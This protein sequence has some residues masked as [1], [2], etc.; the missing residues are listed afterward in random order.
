MRFLHLSGEPHAD[1]DALARIFGVTS[2]TITTWSTE[3]SFPEAVRDPDDRRKRFYSIPAAIRW[4]R[5]RDRAAL[6]G[7]GPE[8]A[9]PPIA[10]S[11]A[12]QEALKARLLKMQHDSEAGLLVS[13]NGVKVEL[14]HMIVTVK[15]RLL[16]VPTKAKARIPHLTRDDVSEIEELIRE[17]LEELTRAAGREVGRDGTVPDSEPA[18]GA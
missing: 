18:D 3:A 16:G 9:I 15:T 13:I 10:R 12:L 14:A 17:A 11:K 4:V 6:V 5:A 7:D 8:G 1:R 2:R